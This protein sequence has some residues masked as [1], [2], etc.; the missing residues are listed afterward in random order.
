MA[1]DCF[2]TIDLHCALFGSLSADSADRPALPGSATPNPQPLGSEGIRSLGKKKFPPR[3][4]DS[5]A[6]SS[7]PFEWFFLPSLSRSWS[8]M[9][10][11]LDPLD[12]PDLAGSRTQ[13]QSLRPRGQRFFASRS[14]RSSIKWIF[15]I[16]Q[17]ILN[18]DNRDSKLRCI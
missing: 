13:K 18:R 14:F 15:R 10:S 2:L 8:W 3:R 6:P 1:P 5:Q 7:P 11:Q 16:A 17:L 9:R 4:L 12:Y